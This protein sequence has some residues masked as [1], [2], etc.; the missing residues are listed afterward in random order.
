MWK[1]VVGPTVLVSLLWIAVSIATS[2][3][4]SWQD[5]W[6]DELLSHNA[7]ATQA[8]LKLE[9]LASGRPDDRSLVDNA[10]ARQALATIDQAALGSA[11]RE[12]AERIRRGIERLASTPDASRS[13]VQAQIID[14][15]RQLLAERSRLLNEL[16]HG[17]SRLDEWVNFCR[18]LFLVAGPALGILVGLRVAGALNRTISQVTVTLR[19]AQGNIEQEIGRV[20]VYPEGD[21]EVLPALEQQVQQVSGRVRHVVS[22]LQQARREAVRAERLAAVGELAAGVA[23]EVRNP[24]TAVKLLVQATADKGSGHAL[25]AEQLQVIQDEILRIEST[26]EGLLDFARPPKPKR[27]SHDLRRTI[28]EAVQLLAGRA[29]HAQVAIRCESGEE[30]L[31]IDGDPQQLRQ[32]VVNL[33]LNGIEAM[34]PGGQLVVRAEVDS[35]DAGYASIEVRDEGPGIPE[36]IFDRLFEPFVTGKEHG[37]GLGLAISRRIVEEHGGTLTAANSD[38]R[39]A[40]FRLRLPLEPSSVSESSTGSTRLRKTH[41]A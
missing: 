6:Q 37:T 20:D 32:V 24:L 30:S 11:D 7:N 28:A 36:T 4:I 5:R 15:C 22:Q 33:L 13:D 40:V 25:S 34:T 27:V 3:Y 14:E 23:H 35:E 19:D 41:A 12:L 29:Q 31:T 1:K 17:R 38:E 18:L 2:S 21:D 10:P 9:E 8:I 26:I 16:L 39:G